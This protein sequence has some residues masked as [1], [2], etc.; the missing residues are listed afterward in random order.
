M[1]KGLKMMSPMDGLTVRGGRLINERGTCEMGITKMAR[2]RKEMKREEKISMISEAYMRAE[3][4]TE[5]GGY[6]PPNR[7]K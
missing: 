1:K 7:R 2:A 3:M 6:T 4:M 5:I